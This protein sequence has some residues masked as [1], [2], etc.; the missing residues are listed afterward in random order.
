MQIGK[1]FQHFRRPGA[2]DA[3]EEYVGGFE[4]IDLDEEEVHQVEP[5]PEVGDDANVA[6]NAEE[7]EEATQYR[8]GTHKCPECGHDTKMYGN[9]NGTKAIS[10]HVRHKHTAQYTDIM[11]RYE[12]FYK[13]KRPRSPGSTLCNECENSFASTSSF[14][15]HKRTGD[16]RRQKKNKTECMQ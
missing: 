4:T 7:A 12:R 1:F 10:S 11:E 13:A 14:N 8:E 3:I 5:P 15:R 6:L 16:C 2:E 9:V